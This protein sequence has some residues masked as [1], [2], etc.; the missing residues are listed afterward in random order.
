MATLAEIRARLQQASQQQ[1]GSSAN[2]P[3]PASAAQPNPPAQPIPPTQSSPPT[4]QVADETPVEEGPLASIQAVADAYQALSRAAS[5]LT[6]E[7][8][9]L[10]EAGEVSSEVRSALTN[11]PSFS[12][13]WKPEGRMQR[14]VDG[15]RIKQIRKWLSDIVDDG[16][17]MQ[18][19]G[20][21]DDE[22]GHD[23]DSITL[24]PVK[25]N[26]DGGYV[27]DEA[28]VLALLEDR[29]K[30]ALFLE[31]FAVDEDWR[32]DNWSDMAEA[33]EM[34]NDPMGV[35]EDTAR[36]GIAAVCQRYSDLYDAMDSSGNLQRLFEITERVYR[37]CAP[38]HEESSSCPLWWVEGRC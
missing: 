7:L 14:V 23:L 4:R 18:L 33:L 12:H 19:E 31:R 24:G 6:D 36:E 37:N 13:S 15:I 35:D 21:Y 38:L 32:A 8:E 25:F 20:Q 9:K 5:R 22:T 16:V 11:L 29:N 1:A 10:V 17:E 30:F 28:G 3:A 27:W 2:Q 34:A 26:I